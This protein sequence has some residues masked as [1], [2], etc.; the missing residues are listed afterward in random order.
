MFFHDDA[1]ASKVDSLLQT[2]KLEGTSA[3]MEEEIKQRLLCV[4]VPY[5]MSECG[6]DGEKVC[7]WKGSED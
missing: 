1:T 5:R 7:C 4:F 3:T 2:L 6:V